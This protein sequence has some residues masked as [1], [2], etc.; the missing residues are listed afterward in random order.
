MGSE[1]HVQCVADVRCQLGRGNFM[2]I[3]DVPQ[4]NTNKKMLQVIVVTM[5][6]NNT[7]HLHQFKNFLTGT[8]ISP[9]LEFGD[10]LTP[11]TRVHVDLGGVAII[12]EDFLLN[13]SFNS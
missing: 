4:L 9:V 2:F 1:L 13:A 8:T 11:G 10:V 6:K 5:R 3:K 12:N 7:N